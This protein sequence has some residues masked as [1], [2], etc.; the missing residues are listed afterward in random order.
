MTVFLPTPFLLHFCLP[1]FTAAIHLLQF[2]S[3][4]LD[5]GPRPKSTSL[6]HLCNLTTNKWWFDTADCKSSSTEIHRLSL[7]SC[8]LLLL[9]A[10]KAS[11]VV[12]CG[13]EPAIAPVTNFLHYPY[14]LPL[15]L[16]VQV[17]LHRKP[18]GF[19]LAI[20]SKALLPCTPDSYNLLFN[21]LSI[22]HSRSPVQL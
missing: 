19:H 1:V 20:S 9:L 22:T 6:F 8:I 2:D 10:S 14:T 21:L 17:T 16:S 15:H 13:V 12:Y 5:H 3:Y 18:D 7:C 4:L 11:S